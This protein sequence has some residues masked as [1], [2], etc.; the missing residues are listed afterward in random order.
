MKRP[1]LL[2][3]FFLLTA[4][5]AYSATNTFP[6]S[7]NAGIGTTSPVNLLDVAGG[8]AI[9]T[10]YAGTDTAPTNGLI[11]QGE[12]SIGTSS[13]NAVPVTIT[14]N[15]GGVP[16]LLSS[17][18]AMQIVGA[19]GQST[20]IEMDGV[21][22]S[23]LIDAVFY[24]TS[25]SAPTAVTSGSQILTFCGL[26]Y[27]GT[28]VSGNQ[29]CIELAAA[30]NWSS[31]SEPTYIYFGTT[32]VGSTTRSERM[33]I[34]STGNV[35][36]GTTSPGD[37]LHVF[38]S[39]NNAL[40][41]VQSGGNSYWNLEA[42]NASNDLAIGSLVATPA[43]T[44]SPYIYLANGS[45]F[46]TPIL[47]INGSTSDVGIGTTSPE[48]TLD[49]NGF[50]RL[51]LNSSA[52]ATCSSSNEGAIALTHLAQVCVCDTTPA[53]HILNTSTACSW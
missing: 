14:S 8:V 7:G 31:T 33:R 28:A 35:G 43:H 19:T 44:V 2:A 41:G 48:A 20:R 36:I 10:S 39:S 29:V 23:S 38:S 22:A 37:L 24:G 30:A 53:W 46:T 16:S 12:V 49:V 18:E 17:T 25:L 11:I 3:A 5:P 13:P 21:G 1:L 9:G 47:Y 15:S 45:T 51:A 26:G 50:Q 40:M 52:P 34:D 42:V 4:A 6:A 32:P 27:N